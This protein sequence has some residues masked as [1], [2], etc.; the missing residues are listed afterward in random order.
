MTSVRMQNDP[1]QEKI[2]NR[3]NATCCVIF[4]TTKSAETPVVCD[5]SHITTPFQ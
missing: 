2:Q 5:F 4:V 1:C 3:L